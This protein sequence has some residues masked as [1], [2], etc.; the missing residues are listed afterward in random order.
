MVNAF[1]QTHWIGKFLMLAG[2]Y[3]LGEV[4]FGLMSMYVVDLLIPAAGFRELIMSMSG[5]TDAP[6]FTSAQ[7][8]A[9]QLYQALTSLGRFILVGYLFLRLMDQTAIAYLHLN[10]CI[11]PRSILLLLLI[12]VFATGSISII[13]EW[14][15]NMHLPS[16][17][18][19]FEESARKME[20]A[21]EAQTKAFLSTASVSGFIVN[22]LVIGVI[23]A[24]A[25]EYFF[26]GVLLR[27]VLDG[28]R[29]PHFAIWF[30]AFFFSLIHYQFFGFFPRLILGAI[31]GYL[32]YWSGS[33]WASII[34]HFF[35]NAMSVVGYFFIARGTV[36]ESSTDPNPWV[37]SLV[38]LPIFILLLI[39]FRKQESYKWKWNGER[40]DDGIHNNG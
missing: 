36:S 38:S 16:F 8:N 15:Q 5:N 4:A 17:L 2:I 24:I 3:L 39:A 13:T 34:A 21:A 31:L 29:K 7:I 35:N 28:T 27:T 18:H 11:H 9:L 1:A 30:S 10:S 19:G 20:S 32:F 23:A 33:L 40:L 6:Q 12:A 22:L 37:A 26:R 25:E 14:N